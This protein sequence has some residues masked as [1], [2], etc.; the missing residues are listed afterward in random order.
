MSSD[1]GFTFTS[2]SPPGPTL[3]PGVYQMLVLM[4]NPP[5]GYSCSTP[6][7]T[8]SGPGVNSVTTFP[9]QATQ[10]D[11]VLPALQ[12]AS[13][14][15]AYDQ[16][17]PVATRVY[18]TT[19]ATGSS[20]SLLTTSPGQTAGKGATQGDIVGSDLSLRGTLKGAVSARTAAK[21]TLAGRDIGTL[22]AGRYALEI[23]DGSKVSGFFIRKG[24][25][26][27]RALTTRAFTGRKTVDLTLTAGSWTY[28]SSTTRPVSFK[29]VA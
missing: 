20:S 5:E 10:F 17:A 21:L 8:L 19:S 3:P 22:R 18:F 26:E 16:N 11:F 12:A 25:D 15:T 29:V 24:K 7:F 1:G 6:V 2:S 27:P 28:Y 13:T 23:T 14:Y 9:Q 4:P